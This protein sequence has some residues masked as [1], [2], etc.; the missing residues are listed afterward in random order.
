MVCQ[1]S[2]WSI[3]KKGKKTVWRKSFCRRKK[4]KILTSAGA[5]KSQKRI[6]VEQKLQRGW[7]RERPKPMWTTN[8]LL[9]EHESNDVE[10]LNLREG[11]KHSKRQREEK[12]AQRNTWQSKKNHLNLGQTQ[13][14]VGTYNS[15]D[16][17]TPGVQCVAYGTLRKKILM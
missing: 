9:V 12:R 3:F 7:C 13:F 15:C 14:K 17:G 5:A 11:R 10:A 8:P 16:K 1:P 4:T 6:V 2:F